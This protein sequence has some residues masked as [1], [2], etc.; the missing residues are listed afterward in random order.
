MWYYKR[1]SIRD[2]QHYFC[3]SIKEALTTKYTYR[4][5]LKLIEM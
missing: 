2:K 1:G 3:I 5:V 4:A